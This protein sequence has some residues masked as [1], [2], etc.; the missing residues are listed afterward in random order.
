MSCREDV[1]TAIYLKLD[2]IETE[3]ISDT[4]IY[5]ENRSRNS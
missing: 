5:H 2:S 4:K 3:D 1:Q